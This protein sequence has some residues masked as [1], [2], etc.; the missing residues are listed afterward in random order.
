MYGALKSDDYLPRLIDARI[1]G[2][3][4]LFSAVCI[5]G[6]KYLREDVDWSQLCQQR[7]L[8]HGSCAYPVT[9]SVSLR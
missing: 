8:H 4:N 9:W 3:L 5:Q 7:N 6:P 1:S 2:D